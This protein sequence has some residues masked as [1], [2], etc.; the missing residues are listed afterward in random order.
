MIKLH[1]EAENFDL[2]E[3]FIVEADVAGTN[4]IVEENN[5]KL[6]ALILMESHDVKKFMNIFID[7]R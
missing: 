6:L 3:N 2:N 1:A 5:L 4:L 7:G